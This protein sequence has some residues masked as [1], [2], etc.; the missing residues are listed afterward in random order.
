[1]KKK[2]IIY[3]RVSSKE[4]ERGGFS[5]PAQIDFLNKYALEKNFEVVATFTEA[6]TAKKTGRAQFNAMVEMLR[7][8]PDIK[9]VLCEKTDRVYRNFKDYVILD[10]FPHLEIHLVKESMIISENAP[11]HI[12]FMHGMKVLMAK[13]YVDNLSEEVQKGIKKKCQLGQYP[14]KAPIGYKNVIKRGVHLIEI[15]NDVAP[16][17]KLAFEL[18]IN[19]NHSFKTLADELT[20]RG[21]Y[22]NNKP[23][24]KHNIESMFDNP[25]YYGDFLHNGVLYQGLHEPIITK[26]LWLAVQKKRKAMATP[27]KIKHSFLYSGMI[28][29]KHCGCMLVG[30]IKK[31]KYIYYHCTG[32]KGGNC[33][34][35]KYLKEST[36]DYAIEQ[37]LKDLYV[38]D[39]HKALIIEHLKEMAGIKQN[40]EKF[41]TDKIIERMNLLRNR[42]KKIYDDKLDGLIDDELYK[43]K[44][45]TWRNEIMDLEIKL[46]ALNKAGN[47]LIDNCIDI[48]ELCQNA[49]QYWKK[50][51]EE[52]KKML[53]NILCSNFYY[54]GANLDIELKSA[55]KNILKS[56][57]VGKIWGK[58]TMFELIARDLYDIII[59]NHHKNLYFIESIKHYK[60]CA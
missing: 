3:A 51:N 59:T 31:Q 14:A 2:C 30:E 48:L 27:K 53:L 11:S 46:S 49:H 28:K 24:K 7:T 15:D 36:I 42:C 10:E 1:M 39:E 21:F 37:I 54:D 5:I 9:A 40:Q 45:T 38:E 44:I 33:K 47:D 41:E 19:T 13:N 52:G 57:S 17:I 25:I 56:A 26:D 6:E 60:K 32:N 58:P 18:Y 20:A 22:V 50:R 34:R 4:Q 29:C 35:N 12:K 55:F 43:E 16:F 23:C 8:N